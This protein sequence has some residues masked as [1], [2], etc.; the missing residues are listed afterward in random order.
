MYL[1]HVAHRVPDG[2]GRGAEMESFTQ[3]GHE[4]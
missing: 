2:S 3:S 4:R 1:A